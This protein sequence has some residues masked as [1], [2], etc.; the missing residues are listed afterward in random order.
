MNLIS[1]ITRYPTKTNEDG[2]LSIDLSKRGEEVE[3]LNRD[4][5]NIFGL[6]NLDVTDLYNEEALALS[7][8]DDGEIAIKI[9]NTYAIDFVRNLQKITGDNMQL[10]YMEKLLLGPNEGNDVIYKE[11]KE[12]FDI[13]FLALLD[14]FSR[15]TEHKG[16]VVDLQAVESDV[17]NLVRNTKLEDGKEKFLA[18]KASFEEILKRDDVGKEED[19]PDR[20]KI[21]RMISKLEAILGLGE[22]IT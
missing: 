5:A 18:K 14:P 12:K 20:V 9:D 1:A 7:A 17:N 15:V 13:K 16:T 22:K 10:R 11:A 8:E 2:G 6:T 19:N 4:I 3:K 21:K